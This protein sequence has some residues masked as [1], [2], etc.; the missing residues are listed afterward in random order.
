MPLANLLCI[1]VEFDD[2]ERGGGENGRTRGGRGLITPPLYA[3]LT[4]NKILLDMVAI[5]FFVYWGL[6][7][8]KT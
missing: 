3:A 7:Q 5:K 2:R 4:M 8:R 1:Y 6:R